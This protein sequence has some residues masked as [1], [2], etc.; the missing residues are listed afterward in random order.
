MLFCGFNEKMLQ[1]LIAFN[2]GLVEHGL[3]ERSKKRNQSIKQTHEKELYD[4]IRFLKEI[5]RIEDSKKREI[6]ENLTKYAL[7]FYELI[8]TE[9]IDD[10]QQIV[11][12]ISQY[13]RDMDNKF[14]SELEDQKDD[15]KQLATFLNTQKI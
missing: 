2:E 12:R 11:Q 7:A 1:G 10:Y 5:H 8:E 9:K 4:M 6:T 13:F 3:I 14:Y 15:M